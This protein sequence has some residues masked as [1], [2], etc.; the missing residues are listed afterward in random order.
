M[1][2]QKAVGWIWGE[3]W[4]SSGSGVERDRKDG[5]MTMRMNGNLQLTGLRR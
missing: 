4:I 2:G 5:Q 1:E 3:E